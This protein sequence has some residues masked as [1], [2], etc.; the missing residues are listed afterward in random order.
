MSKYIKTELFSAK[1][2]TGLPCELE[3]FR[4]KKVRG[5]D[6]DD[7]GASREFGKKKGR[8]YGWEPVCVN[9]KFV[10]KARPAKGVLEKYGI[11]LDEYREIGKALK[12]ILYVGECSLCL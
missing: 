10:P 3:I 6:K 5:A 4:V 12:D 8:L 2:Y 1:A 11:T 9:R 7:F